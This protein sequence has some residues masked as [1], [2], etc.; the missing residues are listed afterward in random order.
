MRASSAWVASLLATALLGACGSSDDTPPAEPGSSSGMGTG[1]SETAAVLERIEQVQQQVDLW[2]D[3]STIDDAQAA[4]AEA[5]LL[6]TGPGVA[7]LEPPAGTPADV[8][9]G[10]L[11]DDSDRPGL[12][13][14][15]KDCAGPDLLGGS[16]DDQEQ[17]WQILRTAIDE[18]APDNNTFP[19]LPSHP[20]RVV[21][22]ATLTLGTSDLDLAQ[23]YS[24]HAQLHVDAARDALAD[25]S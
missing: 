25:C 11:P 13:S 15:V 19:S 6:V 5:R 14:A 7:G 18:W 3:A 16:W 21:G 9:E 22:W 24:G 20:Q 8:T 2:R 12:A 17:R 10:L 4:A 1:T 23:E